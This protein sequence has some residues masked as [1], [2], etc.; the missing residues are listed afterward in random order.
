MVVVWVHRVDFAKQ[1]SS[2]VLGLHCG[3]VVQEGVSGKFAAV[4]GCTV[5]GMK[6]M[7]E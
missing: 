1:G 6:G 2:A 4:A 7:G 5:A 3:A